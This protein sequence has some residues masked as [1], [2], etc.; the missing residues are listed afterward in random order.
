M[1]LSTAS[2]VIFM[3]G[4]NQVQHTDT[5]RIHVYV[6]TYSY[7]ICPLCK[8]VLLLS[9]LIFEH[10]HAFPDPLVTVSVLLH[11]QQTV[12]VQCLSDGLKSE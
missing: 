3:A 11:K 12:I 5:Y 2:R 8:R 9:V 7:I 4:L 10:I 1:Y 6:C